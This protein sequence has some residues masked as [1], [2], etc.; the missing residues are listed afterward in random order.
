MSSAPPSGAS[1]YRS[2]PDV[3]AARLCWCVWRAAVAELVEEADQDV[4]ELLE[5]FASDQP[6]PLRLDALPRSPADRSDRSSPCRQEDQLRTTVPWVRATFDVAGPLEF[7]DRL[8]HRLFPDASERGQL[9]DLYPLG[10]N[11]RKDVR[12]RRAY[13]VEAGLPECG[14]DGLP[15][16]LGQQP[17][18]ETDEWA[19]RKTAIPRTRVEPC[20]VEDAT[21]GRN[22]T[23]DPRPERLRSLTV[24]APSRLE[25]SDRHHDEEPSA[26][27]WHWVPSS[28][29]CITRL[30]H[31]ATRAARGLRRNDRRM[32]SGL[33]PPTFVRVSS[34]LT[35]VDPG[36]WMYGGSPMPNIGTSLSI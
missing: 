22:Y 12:V 14:I 11:E 13:F 23:I 34:N 17:E 9:P 27:P 20:L 25:G 36:K 4:A 30:R 1:M 3:A 31:V 7:V 8:S 21:D 15:P 26:C 19:S 35:F 28:P 16:P 29:R 6:R 24:K 10:R 18:E 33:D 5:F 32:R 2:I